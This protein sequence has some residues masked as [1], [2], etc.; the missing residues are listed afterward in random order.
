MEANS[1]RYLSLRARLA[2]VLIT[3]AVMFTATLSAILYISFRQELSTILIQG[4]VSVFRL[5]LILFGSLLLLVIA[6]TIAA[7]HLV[8]PLIDLR[9]SARRISK[10]ELTHRIT[11][12]PNSREL[13]ELAADLNTMT[14][15]LGNL[16]N[17]LEQRV[18]DRTAE[19]SRRADYLRAASYI[20]RETAEVQ[21]L[22]SLLDTI[23]RLV[24]DQ[25]GFYHTG[26][27]LVNETGSQVILQAA[28]SEGGRQMIEQGY[29]V[30]MGSQEIV[31]YVAA[32]KK[33]RLAL[34]IGGDAVFFNNPDLPMTRSEI[35][36]PLLARNRL[37]GVLDIQSDRPQAFSQ[38]D[39]EIL[40]TFADQVAVAI[41]NVRLLDESRLTL[42]QLEALTTLRTREG[43]SQKLQQEQHVFTYTPLGLGAEKL[44]ADGTNEVAVPL[45]LRGQKIGKISIAR[46][47]GMEWN[48]T[49]ED[50]LTEVASQVSLAVDN[51]RLLEEAT[52]RA[53]QEQIV[54]ELAFRFSQALDIDSLL[55]TAARE[56]GQLPG[57]EQA[58]VFIGEI[59][60]QNKDLIGKNRTSSGKRRDLS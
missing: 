26:V 40:E 3:L 50:L 33:P 22:S 20:A 14:A 36:F 21:D 11:K 4:Q 29:S 28:S 56:L 2:L 32:Q 54:G 41:D 12:L 27:F 59:G 17:D 8:R 53:K 52:Q 23:V 10:G 24:S 25:F 5:I 6:G 7:N 34:D 58:T 19:I 49:D 18:A 55:Q 60:D 16:I 47:D 1:N 42:M 13:A 31:G 48:K 57:V 9:D 44:P 37:L 15:N 46:Q 45:T 38:E 35:A 43:W 39:V 51:L 30:S